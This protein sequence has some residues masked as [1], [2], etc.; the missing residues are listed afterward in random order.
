M[1]TNLPFYELTAKMCDIL[2]LSFVEYGGM[3]FIDKEKVLNSLSWINK[4]AFDYEWNLY[5]KKNSKEILEPLR[6]S[7]K[8]E[9]FVNYFDSNSFLKKYIC[10]EN[11]LSVNFE[12]KKKLIEEII[13]SFNNDKEELITFFNL[14]NNSSIIKIDLGEGDTHQYGK[15]TAIVHL[16]NNMKLVYK[17]RSGAL[18]HAFNDLLEKINL[19]DI[20][21]NFKKNNLLDKETYSWFEYIEHTPVKKKKELKNYYVRCGGI[22]GILYFL[23]GFDIHFENIIAF[24]EYPTLVDLECMFNEKDSKYDVLSIG[25]IPQLNEANNNF[26]DCSGLGADGKGETPPYWQWKNLNSDKLDLVKC[27]GAFKKEKNQPIFNDNSI[28]PKEY[29]NE[30]TEGF[31][32]IC[33]WFLEQ[34]EKGN[35]KELFSSFKN[36]TIRILPRSTQLYSN[37]L[38]NSYEP[39]VLMTKRERSKVLDDN[40]ANFSFL[41]VISKE[42]YEPI[43]EREKDALLRMDIPYFTAN[44]SDIYLEESGQK[45]IENYFKETP[46]SSIINRANELKKNDIKDQVELI[47]DAFAARYNLQKDLLKN[48]EAINEK[49]III[50][51]EIDLIVD[52]IINN[53]IEIDEK[54]QWISYQSSSTGKV[55]LGEFNHS[56][57]SGKLG[58]ALFL[59]MYIKNENNNKIKCIINS[60]VEDLI[61]NFSSFLK[62]IDQNSYASTSIG[63]TGVIYSLLKID[64][65]KYRDVAFKLASF[66]STDLITNSKESDFLEGL[67]GTLT[68]LIE[69]YKV[70]P[71]YDLLKKINLIGNKLLDTRVLDVSSKCHVWKSNINNKPLTGLA[72]GASGIGYALLRLFELTGDF[73]YRKAFYEAVDFEDNYFS[74]KK[75]NWKDLRNEK[76]NFHNAWCY[77]GTGIGLV[78]LHA[79]KILND[80]RFLKDTKNVI[81][82]IQSESTDKL[83]FYCCGNAGKIDFLLDAFAILKEDDILDLVK[84]KIEKLIQ[85]KESIGNYITHEA[86]AIKSENFSFF[87][88]LS[89]IGYVMLKSKNPN[90]FPSIGLF[91]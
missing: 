74:K 84:K 46:F 9:S 43:I 82:L 35:I 57:Y 70:Y 40:L 5:Q 15:S 32:L 33:N 21:I 76:N 38:E 44:T 2:K 6:H 26:F 50:N 12:F 66:F 14:E 80:P 58:I 77:G 45:P 37:I 68:V 87:R 23:K 25:L 36:K 72:H 1:K 24:G 89:G 78:R 29:L 81:S 41:P 61:L 16:N 65:Q 60:I 73:K 83:D 62:S 90:N 51:Y 19:V 7:E 17:P 55:F 56:L 48:T 39:K 59:S 13:S 31:N 75:N 52:K 79:Y 49:S 22:V 63:V 28:T 91:S 88:G 30:I 42:Y 3:K 20:G 47:Q 18:D 27:S 11:L 10:L 71:V 34:A 53:A 69:L 64:A 4:F 67:A 86:T 54:Y 85:K 8:L